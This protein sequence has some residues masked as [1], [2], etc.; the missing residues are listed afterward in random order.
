MSDI[1][2]RASILGHPDRM[3]ATDCAW[4]W[5]LAKQ[6]DIDGH[7]LAH[8]WLMWD[9]L[10]AVLGGKLID[11][12]EVSEFTGADATYKSC[13]EPLSSTDAHVA[14][15][16]VFTATVHYNAV[17]TAILDGEL[18]KLPSGLVRRSAYQKWLGKVGLSSE[19]ASIGEKE[20]PWGVDASNEGR[21]AVPE[22]G[23][24][25]CLQLLLEEMWTKGKYLKKRSAEQL[26]SSQVISGRKVGRAAAREFLDRLPGGS[27]PWTR[28]QPRGKGK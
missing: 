3:S 1:V 10:S 23:S 12:H 17:V 7:T 15:V 28:R 27:V 11:H 19:G 26:L 25:L 5:A 18:E 14:E 21:S 13:V 4:R 8:A 9:R 2:A 16:M 20:E 24:S 22:Q 6:P